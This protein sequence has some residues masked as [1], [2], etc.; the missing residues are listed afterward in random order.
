M[1]QYDWQFNPIQMLWQCSCC[2]APHGCLLKPFNTFNLITSINLSTPPTHTHAN[3]TSAPPGVLP[4]PADE[5][6]AVRRTAV[7]KARQVGQDGQQ[8]EHA[9]G[10][11]FWIQ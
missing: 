3:V 7:D 5:Q 1:S 11:T 6:E 10:I 8:G 9:N 4:V 2:T